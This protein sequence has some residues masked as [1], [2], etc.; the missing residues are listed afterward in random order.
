MLMMTIEGWVLKVSF[1]LFFEHS[2][3]SLSIPFPEPDL[4]IDE[5]SPDE[6]QRVTATYLRN[7]V[8]SCVEGNKVRSFVRNLNTIQLTYGI[9]EEEAPPDVIGE[10]V[11][12]YAH[13]L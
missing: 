9:Q 10:A 1:C 6:E 5:I 12:N 3:N 2:I 11:R 13:D 8:L 4:E 7:Y